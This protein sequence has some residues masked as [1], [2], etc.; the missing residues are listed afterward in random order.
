MELQR[1]QKLLSNYGY[2]SRRKAEVLIQDGRVKVNGKLITIG[3][4]A[5]L[6]D[7]IEVDNKLVI[8]ER[9]MYLMLNKP[10]YCVTALKDDQHKTV[11]DYVKV[12]ERV[13]PV[14]RLDYNSSGL[15]L[16]TND[17]DFSNKIMHPSNEVKKTYLV[18]VSKALRHHAAAK[19]EKGVTLDDGSKTSRAKVY[20]HNPLLVEITVHEGKNRI[21]RRMLEAVGYEVRSLERVRVGNLDLGT[22]K[23]GRYRS[24]NK[25]D[26][27]K[28]FM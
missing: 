22:L 21:I 20:F 15:L 18:R 12:K 9:K 5:T 1:V 25:K 7:K 10:L 19:L 17:G 24:L 27:D 13:F 6:E 4:K 14:G 16:L 8:K 11:M 23:P 3:D 2:C 28:I 26:I